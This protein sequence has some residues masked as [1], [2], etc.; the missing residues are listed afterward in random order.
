MLLWIILL[1]AALCVASGNVTREVCKEKICS[2][3]EVE[4]DLHVDCEKRGLNTLR[5]LTGPSSHFYHLLLHGNSLSRLFPNEFANFY[6]AV[7]LHLESNGLHDIVPGAFLG[8]QLVK[9]LHISNNKIRSFK[10][11]T[12]LGLDD[13]EYLQADFNLLRDI[14]PA[15]FRDLNK[16]EVLILN[17]NLISALPINV[18]QHV[19]ITHLDL[20][21][22]RIKTLPYEGILEQIPGIAEVLLEDNPWDCNCELVSLKEW[23]ENIPRNALIGRVVCEAPTRLQGSDL[24]ETSEADLCPSQSEGGDSSLPAPPTQEETSHPTPYKPPRNPGGGPPTPGVNGSKSNSKSPESWQL[25][26]KPT[27]VMAAADGNGDGGEEQLRNITCPQPCSCK[28]VGVRKGLAVNCEGKKIESLASLKPK[29]LAAHELN[30]RDNNIHAVKKNQLLGY[31]SL[32]LLDLGGNNI[33]VVDN[34]TFQNQSELRWLYMDKNYL[35]TL[36]AEMFVGLV[37]L[38]YLSLEYNDIQLIVAGAFSPMPNLRVLFLNN[39]LL[40][41]LPVDAF[42]GISLSKISL[43]NNYFTYL[44]VTGVLEQ[45]NSIIQIDLHGNPWDCSCNIVPFKRWTE[46]L[47]ADVI[48]S[49]LK[50]EAPEEFWKRDFRY[51]RNDLMC[52]KLFDRAVPTPVSKNGTY[53]QD[54]GGTRSNSYLEPNRVSISVLVP[55][56]LLV[57]VTS[58]FTV[59]GMLVFILRNRK[60]SK[61]RD[62]NSSASEINSL[63]TVCDSSYW[64][65]GPYHADGGAHR[66]FDCS[67]HLSAVD[68]A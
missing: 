11:S 5:H 38:E 64:H 28:L 21:G 16:L 45:L 3:S 41:A 57:F 20:R 27:P 10:K 43:H 65:S 6:N 17:D 49:D 8:L 12:F 48:V 14:D 42:V 68:D 44:P 52:P 19:P 50:C 34:G 15:V 18:F 47:G 54:S 22:N 25:K 36:M 53:A 62:G 46:K 56:L 30:M 29:P 32:N 31:S 60:R 37:N 55:G 1:N 66:G 51:V 63:Q 23:L 9:R 58:A 59:V 40:K 4:G 33:K 26:T 2:C 7:S 35:D 39:N 61:R 67:T 13:L 24:N